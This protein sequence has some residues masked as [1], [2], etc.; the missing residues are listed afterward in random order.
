MDAATGEIRLFAGNYAPQNWALCQGQTLPINGNEV[1]YSL[2]GTTFGGDGRTT[3]GLPDL[4]GRV[5]VN[6]GQL[7]GGQNY[8]FASFGGTTQVTL[9]QAQIPAH[10]HSFTIT[11]NPANSIT[12]SAGAYVGIPVDQVNSRATEF[13]LP[14]NSSDTTQKLVPMDTDSVTPYQGGNQ[15]HNNLQPYA[16]LNYIICLN[17]I[18]P[19][20]N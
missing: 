11:T 7:T 10:Q 14:N 12:P 15:P 16:T 6:R 2:I 17:G 3:F 18:Y 9:T 1:L 8:A 4:R 20:F 13:F 5:I 19:T